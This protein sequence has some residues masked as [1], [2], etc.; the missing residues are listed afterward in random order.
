MR[1]RS[2]TIRALQLARTATAMRRLL[3]QRRDV[4]PPYAGQ[5]FDRV[6]RAGARAVLPLTNRRRRRECSV[7]HRPCRARRCRASRGSYRSICRS[8]SWQPNR[9][10]SGAQEGRARNTLRQQAQASSPFAHSCP[11]EHRH[12]LFT[13]YAECRLGTLRHIC[14]GPAVGFFDRSQSTN[15]LQRSC[16]PSAVAICLRR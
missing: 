10:W 4:G 3:Q 16:I 11:S 7:A 12:S 6:R 5:R 15:R 9:C 13:I 1:A 2:R 14:A 8:A